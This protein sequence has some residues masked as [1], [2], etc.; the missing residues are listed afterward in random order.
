MF[1]QLNL[2]SKIVFDAIAGVRVT[3]LHKEHVDQITIPSKEGT[4]VLTAHHLVLY[5]YQNVD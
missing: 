1:V 2:I 3:D 5:H 4:Y